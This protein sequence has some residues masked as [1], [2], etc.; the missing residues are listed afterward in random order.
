MFARV[1]HA[2]FPA[3]C[4]GLWIRKSSPQQAARPQSFTSYNKTSLQR[5]REYPE[6]N[7]SEE[8]VEVG[9]FMSASSPDTTTVPPL[10]HTCQAIF[11][12]LCVNH[13]YLQCCRS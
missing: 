7:P 5:K 2:P 4:D 9:S 1:S 8:L 6:S 13:T 12:V 11:F 3:P 10:A